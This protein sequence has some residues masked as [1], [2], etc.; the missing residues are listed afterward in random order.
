MTRTIQ[1]LEE[2]VTT[3]PIKKEKRDKVV[4]IRTWTYEELAKLGTLT[5]DFDDVI[6]RLLKH[7]KEHPEKK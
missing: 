4:R 2:T 5:D 3:P 1:A 7:Y 6:S